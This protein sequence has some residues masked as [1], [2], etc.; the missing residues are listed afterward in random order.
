[1]KSGYFNLQHVLSRKKRKKEWLLLK[2][3]LE[4]KKPLKTPEEKG[5]LVRK[6]L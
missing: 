2:S 3:C 1:M 6:Y 5:F 4:K